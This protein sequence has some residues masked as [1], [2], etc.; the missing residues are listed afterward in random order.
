MFKNIKFHFYPRDMLK[1]FKIYVSLN[2]VRLLCPCDSPGKNTGVGCHFLFQGIFLTQG[3][4]LCLLCLLHWQGDSLPLAPPGKRMLRASTAT[5][6]ATA[7]SLQS[8]PTVWPHR[9]QS[10]RLPCPWDS[11]GKNT[12]VGCHFLLQCIESEKWKWSRLVVSDSWRPHRLQPTRLL[13][14]W[15]FP[16]KSSGVS[17]HCLCMLLNFFPALLRGASLENSLCKDWSPP[18]VAFA[19][20]Q[21]GWSK[22][23]ALSL[24]VIK[25]KWACCLMSACLNC[26]L[27]NL[28]MRGCWGER[29][30][31]THTSSL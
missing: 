15:D 22:F 17:C 7:K 11:P 8:C 30:V 23:F 26:V 10:T 4:K 19:R 20:T 6:A 1:W 28:P 12:G 24:P 29:V 5:A 18:Q 9:R 14:P 3:S 25:Q 31:G 27:S 16:G 13:C 21:K 2:P